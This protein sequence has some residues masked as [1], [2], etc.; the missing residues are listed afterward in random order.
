MH[1]IEVKSKRGSDD[2]DIE[3]GTDTLDLGPPRVEG[4]VGSMIASLHGVKE[5]LTLKVVEW[6]RGQ[7]V[8]VLVDP[9]ASHNFID[10]GFAKDLKIKGFKGF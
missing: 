9:R 4:T 5:Y 3:V 8:M 6:S 1:Y 7:D 10:V 2:L